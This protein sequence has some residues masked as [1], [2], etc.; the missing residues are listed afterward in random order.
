MEENKN[1]PEQS[2][3]I[4]DPVEPVEETKQAEPVV[5]KEAPSAPSESL[6]AFE[7]LEVGAKPAEPEAPEVFVPEEALAPTKTRGGR[8]KN[9]V[10][11]FF[12][13]LLV[14]AFIYLAGVV[15]IYILEF[16]PAKDALEQTQ[17]DLDQASQ[18]I[19]DMQIELD[20]A[21]V[22]FSYNAYLQVLADVY[23]ARLALIEEDTSS[24]KIFLAD[25]EQN[26]EIILPDVAAFDQSLANSLTQRLDL[27]V[28][29]VDSDISRALQDAEVLSDDLMKVF[30]G[31]Y[32]AD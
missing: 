24:A 12:I 14:F 20:Q 32:A 4:P 16:Q 27:V 19:A 30:D 17:L 7:P 21:R 22:N 28:T 29:N 18:Q 31:I 15:T 5:Q 9:A 26:L 8:F 23:G 6:P 10:R 3:E 2:G 25:A 11:K 1:L 13:W